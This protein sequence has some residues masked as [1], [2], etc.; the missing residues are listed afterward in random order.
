MVW[1]LVTIQ[2]ARL[3]L[4][5]AVQLPNP[6][7]LYGLDRIGEHHRS[8]LAGLLFD[9]TLLQLEIALWH[10]LGG[11]I[12]GPG[13]LYRLLEGGRLI[14]NKVQCTLSASQDILCRIGRITTA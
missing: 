13:K 5:S 2:F 3:I 6:G 7:T 9:H 8:L 4:V 1:S 10:L 12:A 11:L 14:V